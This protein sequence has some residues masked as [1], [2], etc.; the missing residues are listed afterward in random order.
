M[1]SDIQK[2]PYGYLPSYL[3]E[4]RLGDLC[5]NNGVQTGPFGSQLHQE[6]YVATGTPIITVE[7]LGDNRIIHQNL[8]KVSDEDKVR[9]SKYSLQTGDI[10]FSRVGSVDRRAI[11][12]EHEDGWL[13]SGRCLRIRPDREKL[14]PQW[15][16]YF[17]GLPAF[18]QYIRGIAVG[19][20]M[21]SINTKILSDIPIYFPSLSEQRK[22]ANF[23]KD[24]DDKITINIS[25]NQKLDEIAQTIFKSWF[26]NF[27][28]VKA[29]IDILKQGGSHDE[30]IIS[31]MAV[32]AGK[33]IDSLIGLKYENPESYEEIKRLAELFP[34]SMIDSELGKI[35]DGWELVSL[36][37]IASFVS[38]K[39]IVSDL[40][41]ENYIS[42][43]NMLP[44]KSG[45]VYATSLPSSTTTAYF[46][47]NDILISNIRP[48]FKKIWFARFSGG[49]SADVLALENKESITSEYLY[50]LLYQD[51]FFSYMMQ[52]S[53]GVKMPR[54]DKVAIMDWPCV[55]PEKK[56]VD[57]FSKVV[58]EFYLYIDSHNRENIQLSQLRDI[59]L[60]KLLFGEISLPE[61]EELAKEADYV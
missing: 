14:D 40:T 21:P 43:E 15:L 31:A 57:L 11:V 56:L 23:L 45:V 30:A 9:L 53:K 59:L 26:V 33:N 48:Y 52:T 51:S 12:Q 39:I 29:K 27:E 44:N 20:T 25:I 5:I 36:R 1:T 28:P 22:A 46:K 2:T 42:T 35:P 60:P 17:F 49:R 37:N 8:P 58:K 38:G 4:A 13:F 55:K 61:A 6:D 32:I 18:K 41:N 50:N 19:A 7:H 34:S 3:C 47:A 10:V 54:G 24:L 16:S